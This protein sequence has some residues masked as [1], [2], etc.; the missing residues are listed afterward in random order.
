[1]R[2]L[3][4]ICSLFL[5]VSVSVGVSITPVQQAL[6]FAGGTGSSASPYQISTCAELLKIDDT[7]ANLSKAY[8]FSNDVDCSGITV[9]PM[10]NGSTYF[11]GVLN[12][13]NFSLIGLNITCTTGVFCA[14]FSTVSGT[15]EIKN[16]TVVSPSII[17]NGTYNMMTAALVAYSGSTSNPAFS[18][19]TIS[20]G[21]I[22]AGVQKTSGTPAAGSIA[23][24]IYRGTVTDSTSSATVRGSRYV[25]G[26][27]GLLG[28][29]NTLCSAGSPSLSGSSYSGNV[30]GSSYVGGLVG[31]FGPNRGKNICEIRNSFNSGT[32]TGTVGGTDTTCSIIGGIVGQLWEAT[33]EDSYNTGEINGATNTCDDV[34]GVV[35]WARGNSLSNSAFE[36]PT[37]QRLYST[38]L[39]SGRSRIGGIVGQCDRGELMVSHS[40]GAI[41]STGTYAGGL[42]GW[43]S[44]LTSDSYS[45]SNVSGSSYA[46]GLIGGI[47]YYGVSRSYSTSTSRGLVAYVSYS[48][49]AS[50]TGAFWDKTLGSATSECGASGKTTTEMKTVSTFTASSWNFTSG[51][52]V[53]TINPSVNDGYPF[54]SSAGVDISEPT[55]TSGALSANGTTVVLTFSES[56]HAT[57]A[58]AS[59]FT[60]TASA[61][62]LTPTSAVVSGSTVVLTLSPALGPL[63]VITVAYLA[64]ASNAATSNAAVQ[65]LAGNDAAAF[66]GRS[67]TNNSTADIIAPTAS[68][69]EPNTPSSSRTLSYTL[70]FSEAVSGIVAG[71]FASI[72]TATG[73]VIATASGTANL[74]VVIT[75]TCS[76]DGTIMLRLR[77][78]SVL[79]A[80]SNTGPTSD[81]VAT[82][83]TI[84][85]P[86]APTTTV[87]ATTTV[88]TVPSATGVSTSVPVTATTVETGQRSIATVTTVAGNKTTSSTTVVATTG[89]K[90]IGSAGVVTTTTPVITTTTIAKLSAIDVPRTEVGGS[91]VL[92]GGKVV[93]G[94]ITRENN[95]LTITAGPMVVRIWAVAADGGKLALDADGRLRVKAGDS[96]TVEAIG[97]SFNTRTEVRLYSDPVLLGRTD[98]DDEGVM[99]ASYEIPEG[100]PSGNHNVVL[101]G[102]RDKGPVTMA[103]SVVLG[104]ESS[105]KAFTAV[106]IGVLIAAGFA[107]LMLPA[108]LRR[109]RE[110]E[111]AE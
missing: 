14:L 11:S 83:I 81:A 99:N 37:L 107:A 50:C 91:S 15:P 9:V 77:S 86:T 109:R 43:S 48:P 74:S 84:T 108:F 75:V 100:I 31:E 92:I 16:L 1:M 80:A 42:A 56:L 47:S 38:G 69:T 97:F 32:V 30:S 18:N 27:V 61:V 78:G 68:W 76:S 104:E 57:T 49:S 22:D 102:E 70:T 105:S 67:A 64:P 17:S 98:V 28:D 60:V 66:S 88:T 25:G 5:L 3:L 4:R 87:S 8:E 96:V 59:A 34:G 44:C 33:V 111:S 93:E 7:T 55:L 65:D 23:G 39:V 53:W 52:A 73:C 82:S 110:D 62:L 26:L 19:I 89:S 10:A 46:G 71:D 63:A 58:A 79:D 54:H 6:A 94:V 41:T 20:G 13:N 103:L 106:L 40:T 29:Q 35:G 95:R 24:S 45:R 2:K 85:S 90:G 51:S 12:G 101:A 36:S 21:L 72:G